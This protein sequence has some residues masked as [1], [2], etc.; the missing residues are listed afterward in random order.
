V[1]DF[2]VISIITKGRSIMKKLMTVTVVAVM[3]FTLA[4][5]NSFGGPA[6]CC[7]N[8]KKAVAVDKTKASCPKLQGMT[9]AEKKAM[10]AKCQQMIQNCPK[11]KSMSSADMAKAMKNC[12]KFKSMSKADKK[13]ML[14]K[15]QKMVKTC[16]KLKGMDPKAQKLKMQKCPSLQKNMATGLKAMQ[17]KCAKT[18]GKKSCAK[19]KNISDAD[20]KALQTKCTKKSASSATAGENCPWYKRWFGIHNTGCAND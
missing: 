14:A 2:E 15:C 12:P 10:M 3:M 11:M 6:G 20:K 1:A 16:P 18:N 9:A 5:A 13:A 17:A 4:I 7:A 8:P 19:M